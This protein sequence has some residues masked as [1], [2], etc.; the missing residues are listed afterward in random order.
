MFVPNVSIYN[1]SLSLS[2]STFNNKMTIN[3]AFSYPSFTYE[4]ID[5]IA[6]TMV[7]ILTEN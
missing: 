2:I 7:K 3:F 4:K 6:Q 1:Y 5:K